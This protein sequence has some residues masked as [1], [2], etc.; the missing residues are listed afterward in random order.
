MVQKHD[1]TLRAI[2]DKK[3]RSC[4]ELLIL[5]R[6]KNIHTESLQ[7]LIFEVYKWLNNISPPFTWDY[8]KQKK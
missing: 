6:K 3:T 7:I 4:G 5:S 8:F 2:F 1:R